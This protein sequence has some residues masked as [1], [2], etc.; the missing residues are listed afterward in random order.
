MKAKKSKN[1]SVV[2]ENEQKFF[3]FSLSSGICFLHK[4]HYINSHVD[5]TSE[6]HTGKRPEMY[7]CF[8]PLLTPSPVFSSRCSGKYYCKQSQTALFG[9]DGENTMLEQF[10]VGDQCI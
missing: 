2:F 1:L 6:P 10:L 9:L 8:F 7:H 5:A 3:F 4:S